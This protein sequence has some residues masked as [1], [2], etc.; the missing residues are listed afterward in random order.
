MCNSLLRKGA[1]GY[2]GVLLLLCFGFGSLTAQTRK[3]D[4]QSA[5]LTV[6]SDNYLTRLRPDTTA[7]SWL[8]PHIAISSRHYI[9]VEFGTTRAWMAGGTNFFFPYKAAGAS[10]V[11]PFGGLGSGQGFQFGGVVDFSL[12]DFVGLQ[13]KLRYFNAITRTSQSG[14]IVASGQ[15]GLPHSFEAVSSYLNSHTYLGADAFM[16]YQLVPQKY[17]ALGGA[18]IAVPISESFSVTRSASNGNGGAFVPAFQSNASPSDAYFNSFRVDLKLGIGTFIPLTD[19]IVMTPELVLSLPV[20]SYFSKSYEAF[21]TNA[22]VNTPRQWYATASV[23]I[24]FPNG[25]F[26]LY[27]IE[28]ERHRKYLEEFRHASVVHPIPLLRRHDIAEAP[29][30]VIPQKL[31]RD[32]LPDY[33]TDAQSRLVRWEDIGPNAA[34]KLRLVVFFEFGKAALASYN[35]VGLDRLAHTMLKHPQ[36]IVEIAAYT[37]GRGSEQ[38]NLQL[39]QS[40]A[41]AIQSYLTSKGIDA[42]RLP[43]KGY[44]R[45]SPVATNDTP[46][47]R[48]SN[49]RVE[50]LVVRDQAMLDE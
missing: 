46:E 29:R 13:G 34:R 2:A 19:D 31:E 18:G 44:G 6:Y 26:S 45:A 10:G 33:E 17:Y 14:S 22:G 21:Y 36:L 11:L 8:E 43:A 23:S 16:R 4:L 12:S 48:A 20:T 42:L 35:N 15:D 28:R 25:G 49:R 32:T 40:R 3:P 1:V 27:A 37:D 50:F 47:G 38:R 30:Q 24:K 7:D 9:G 41:D 39:S 5:T